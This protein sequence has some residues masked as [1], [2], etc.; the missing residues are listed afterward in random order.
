MIVQ[1]EKLERIDREDGSR[2]YRDE[3]GNEFASVTSVLKATKTDGY[4]LKKWKATA[5]KEKKDEAEYKKIRGSERGNLLHHRIEDYFTDSFHPET[6][7]EAEFVEPYWRSVLPFLGR[8][9]EA[10]GIELQVAHKQL[11]YA[12][13]L[14]FLGIVDGRLALVD[15]KTADKEKKADWIQDYMLQACAYTAVCRHV[16]GLVVEVAHIVVAIPG[17]DA[18]VF[19]LELSD[20]QK[21][22]PLWK[23]RLDRFY[24]R[25]LKRKK[26]LTRS[27]DE[28]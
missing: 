25:P 3:A 8:V 6:E 27:A 24:K 16:L 22:W 1:A 19:T 17:Q 18:Q 21:L 14:D 15:W 23:R 10:V 13:S 2:V 5:S 9:S 20:L 28:V 26:S 7:E 12:G 11:K 4:A